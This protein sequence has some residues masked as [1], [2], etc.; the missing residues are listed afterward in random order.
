MKNGVFEP[1]DLVGFDRC[2]G[3]IGMVRSAF[4][5]HV[6]NTPD[7]WPLRVT[8]PDKTPHCVARDVASRVERD[9]RETAWHDVDVGVF[10]RAERTWL[11]QQRIIIERAERGW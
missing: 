9:L 4:N 10:V 6:C 1:I 5:E 2:M 8:L 11:G 7:K 3:F